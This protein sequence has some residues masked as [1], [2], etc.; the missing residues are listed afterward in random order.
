ML[1]KHEQQVHKT[2]QERGKY[3]DPITTG[4][5]ETRAYVDLKQLK[6]LWFNTG[7]LC[8]LS[9][10][11]CYIESSPE[12]DELSYISAS[13]VQS[14]LTEIKQ[15]NLGTERIAFTGGEPFLNP[16]MIEILSR[17]LSA[18]YPALVL[19]N[20]YRIMNRHKEALVE[21][22]QAYGANL[23]IRVSL[24]HYTS[25]V[26]ESERGQRTFAATVKNIKWLFDEGFNVSVAGRS[27]TDETQEQALAG[28]Q[29]LMDENEIGLKLQVGKNIVIFPEMDGQRDVPEITTDCLGILSVSPDDQMCATERMIVKR[30]GQ[31]KPTVLPCTLLTYDHQF[32]LGTT[33]AASEKRVQLNHPYCA[34]FCVLGGAS[35]S[36]TS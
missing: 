28:Y 26:H 34:Q 7:T 25:E 11:N 21:L 27:L 2:F 13:E 22:N 9:C 8:N 33:L 10:E 29:R 23:S 31:D 35:C 19:T 18:G 30:K 15:L 12:N 20:A 36:S 16:D 1:L 17:V 24:D 14:Y 5:G 32:D 6:T 3:V 4:K